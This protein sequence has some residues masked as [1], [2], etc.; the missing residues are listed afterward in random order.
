[1]GLEGLAMTE[2]ALL[3]RKA[4]LSQAEVGEILGIPLSSVSNYEQGI[5]R[6]NSRQM[7]ILRGL[8]LFGTRS[9]PQYG[10]KEGEVEAHSID[11]E[12]QALYAKTRSKQP[13][14]KQSKMTE[15]TSATEKRH[16]QKARST[17]RENAKVALNKGHG[18]LRRK[19]RRE[20]SSLKD[21]SPPI[22]NGLVPPEVG[23]LS[24]PQTALPRIARD[25]RAVRAIEMVVRQLP[26]NHHLYNTDCRHVSFLKPNSVHL[27]LTSPPY[28]TLKR[29]RDHP[30]QLGFVSDYEEF[31]TELDKVW[32]LCHHA[33]VPGGRLI[34]V[35]GDV[36]LSRRQNGGE[37]S[38]VPL[39][40]AIQQ[41]CCSLGFTN[42]APIIWSKISNAAYEASGNG[43]GFLGKPYEPNAVIKNDIEFILM[44]RKPGGYRSPSLATR[45]LSVVPAKHHKAWFQQIWTDVKGASTKHHPAPFPLELAERLIR[46]F[47]FVADTVYD[48]FLGSGTT[49]V[50]AKKWGRNSIGVEVDPAY[51]RDAVT[52]VSESADS[53]FGSTEILVHQ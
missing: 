45:I 7:S 22:L 2:F 28:W 34:C 51:F 18:A 11:A 12:P 3:M 6:P 48:P 30:D 40:A 39:H 49:S 43:G 33:L 15:R 50:A 38:V 16:S 47:S 8:Q 17:G 21:A 52:R 41:R 5:S 23:D 27:V 20:K 1:M 24:D 32:G 42:L 36:C 25:E 29:Y 14:A 46:M 37:H 31:L 44:E 19:M 9:R 26:T 35:V 10:G 53:L 13:R 4:G